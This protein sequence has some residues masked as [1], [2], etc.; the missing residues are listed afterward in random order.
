MRP[1]CLYLYLSLGSSEEPKHP[2]DGEYRKAKQ[3]KLPGQA[4][5]DLPLCKDGQR[6]NLGEAEGWEEGP[7]ASS[8]VVPP[9]GMPAISPSGPHRKKMESALYGCA[10]LLASVALGFDVRGISRAEEELPPKGDMKIQEGVLQQASRSSPVLLSADRDPRS[11]TSL[12]SMRCLPQTNGDKPPMCSTQIPHKPELP[13]Q[14]SCPVCPE[15]TQGLALGPSL[16]TDHRA[17]E[18]LSPCSLGQ[19]LDGNVPHYASP[20]DTA[21]HHRQTS[22]H[23]NP[24]LTPR[25]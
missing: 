10:V 11:T 24:L 6:Q 23:G 18:S 15:S 7:T 1:Q 14:D 19:T 25:R 2:A 13:T 8:A 4:Y 9:R 21:S 17:L 16:E 20:K 3:M 5:T 12:L 22:S